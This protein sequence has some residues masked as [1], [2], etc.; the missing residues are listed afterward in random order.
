MKYWSIIITGCA[1]AALLVTGHYAFRAYA[2]ARQLQS[3]AEVL[4]V[5]TRTMRHQI[6]ELEQKVRMFRRVE[7]FVKKAEEKGLT[8]EKWATYEVSIQDAV[9]FRELA[10]IV[11]QCAHNRN[12]YYRPIAF[13][14][15]VDQKKEMVPGD[16]HGMAPVVLNEADQDDVQSDLALALKGTFLVRH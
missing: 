14:A 8:P 2:G 9:T 5:R 6:G 15:V 16:G 1:V 10:Q 12:L 11:E 3:Q 13:H 7:H 4:A